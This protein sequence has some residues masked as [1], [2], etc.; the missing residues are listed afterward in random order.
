MDEPWEFVLNHWTVT[1]FLPCVLLLIAI[2][3]VIT[4]M[5]DRKAERK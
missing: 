2:L 4:R 3:A 1:I 5:A